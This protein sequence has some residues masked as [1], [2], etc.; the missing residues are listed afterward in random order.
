MTKPSLSPAGANLTIAS[1]STLCGLIHVFFV[2]KHLA[3]AVIGY[4]DY[5]DCDG[6]IANETEVHWTWHET[7]LLNPL[8]P[9]LPDCSWYKIPKQGKSIP[10]DN[11]LY[12]MTIKYFQWSQNRPNEHKIYQD[13]PL[14]DPGLKTNH[15]ATLLQINLTGRFMDMHYNQVNEVHEMRYYWSQSY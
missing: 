10:N 15:P 5:V 3:F 9:G 7:Y 13:F 2:L 14:Q 6:Y 1:H 12:Q 11:K 4:S 8:R